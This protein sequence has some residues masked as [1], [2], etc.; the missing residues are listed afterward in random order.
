MKMY[1]YAVVASIAAVSALPANA[2]TYTVAI[3]DSGDFQFLGNGDASVTYEGVT[4]S[5]SASRS[6]GNLFNVGTGF[7]GAVS[8]VLS[9]Q[10]QTTGLPNILITL[11]RLAYGISISYS[12]FRDSNVFFQFSNGEDLLEFNQGNGFSYA[13]NS[14]FTY[15][16]A[17]AFTSILL[18]ASDGA[19]NLNNGLNLGQI[20]YSDVTG[21]V[22]EPAA[23]TMM[24]GGM[25]VVGGAMRR[26][27]IRA[28]I[29]FA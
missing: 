23:W 17:N 19:G 18:I 4:F 25:G 7:S 12:T 9:S 5:Q 26:R 27:R 16:S 11:P 15:T 2:T 1:L 8:A 13:L 10:Q 20:S 3:P 28:K 21:G 14:L 22:P 24:I 6:N 29:S